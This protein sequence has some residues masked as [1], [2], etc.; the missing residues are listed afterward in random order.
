MQAHF[1]FYMH[2]CLAV[3]ELLDKKERKPFCLFTIQNY[4]LYIFIPFVPIQSQCKISS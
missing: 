1:S 2:L 4:Y 3:S